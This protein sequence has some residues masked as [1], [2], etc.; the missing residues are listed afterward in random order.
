M[1]LHARTADR[2][3]PTLGVK[4]RGLLIVDIFVKRITGGA[5]L[6]SQVYEGLLVSFGNEQ[7]QNMI[8][9]SVGHEDYW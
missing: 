5:S 9:L 7:C 3:R 2:N 6:E 4:G 8:Y 1:V